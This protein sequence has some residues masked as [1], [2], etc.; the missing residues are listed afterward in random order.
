MSQNIPHISANPKTN[1]EYGAILASLEVT[2]GDFQPLDDDYED[3]SV[4]VDEQTV[5]AGFDTFLENRDKSGK[6]SGTI[7]EVKGGG[8]RKVYDLFNDPDMEIIPTENLELLLLDFQPEQIVERVKSFKDKRSSLQKKFK[9]TKKIVSA[10]EIASGV[11]G[12]AI[13]GVYKFAN[14]TKGEYFI[15]LFR[16]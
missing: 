1:E 12:G 2:E 4:I 6:H 11:I 16:I 13:E 15:T 8:E 14:A 7:S 5:E 3:G 9:L 10:L